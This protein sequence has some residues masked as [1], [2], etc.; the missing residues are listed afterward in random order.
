MIS[1]TKIFYLFL[2]LFFTKDDRFCNGLHILEDVSLQKRETSYHQSDERNH[3]HK[4]S[5]ARFYIV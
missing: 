1:C 2:L 4:L 3:V 5:E